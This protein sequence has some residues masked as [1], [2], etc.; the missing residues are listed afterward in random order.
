[1]CFSLASHFQAR[2]DSRLEGSDHPTG[3]TVTSDNIGPAAR[4]ARGPFGVSAWRRFR[5]PE[6]RYT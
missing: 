2:P 3:R 5:Q 1:M 4:F 6:R